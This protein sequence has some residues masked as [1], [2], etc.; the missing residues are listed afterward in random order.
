MAEFGGFFIFA[1]IAAAVLLVAGFAVLAERRRSAA[2]R[3][4]ARK[5]GLKYHR[6]SRGIPKQYKFLDQLRQGDSRYAFNILEGMYKGGEV[7]AFDYH[8]ATGSGKNRQDHYFTFFMSRLERM[9]PELRI[10]PE[11]VFSK[12]GQMI[13]YEDIDF[14]SIEFSRAF[15]VRSKDRKF[16]YDICDTRMMEY[17]L[18]HPKLSFEIEQ[19][20]LAI[21][22]SKRLKPEDVPGGLEMLLEVR[23]HFP[24]YLFRG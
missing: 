22:S 13:G 9:F 15:T 11:N 8:Y 6:K 18:Q 19:C 24:E 1:L 14:E 16:A 5:L 7:R 23:S 21:G 3:E 2:F 4:I 12:L 10:Y 17:L 20:W